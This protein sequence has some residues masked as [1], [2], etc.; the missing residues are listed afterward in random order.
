MLILHNLETLSQ[1]PKLP[2]TQSNIVMFWLN[3][4]SLGANLSKTFLKITIFRL[5]LKSLKTRTVE[6]LL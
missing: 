3:L 2:K 1:R 5:S 4:E 6:N